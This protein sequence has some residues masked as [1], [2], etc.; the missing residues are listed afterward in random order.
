[1]H[2]TMGGSEDFQLSKIQVFNPK[3]LRT[4][5]LIAKRLPI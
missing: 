4:A 1:M 2:I 5:K 3:L